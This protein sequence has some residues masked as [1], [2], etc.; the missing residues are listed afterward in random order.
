MYLLLHSIAKF[1]CTVYM[2]ISAGIHVI[3]FTSGGMSVNSITIRGNS[4]CGELEW[5]QSRWMEARHPGE[6]VRALL[7]WGGRRRSVG[8]GRA[9]EA[10][11]AEVSKAV[12]GV[13]EVL[14]AS[15]MGV[16]RG[17]SPT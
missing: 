2:Q 12:T 8:G 5:R 14:R 7:A 16:N 3:S 4:F 13:K 15:G 1:F 11:F 6:C 17:W 10:L 9:D